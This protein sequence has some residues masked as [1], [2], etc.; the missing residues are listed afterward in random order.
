MSKYNI[1]LGEDLTSKFDAS[2][3]EKNKTV[4]GLTYFLFF[5]PFL[6]APDSKYARFHANQSLVLLIAYVLGLLVI[7]VVSTI[8]SILTYFLFFLFFLSIIPGIALLLLSGSMVYLFI[9]GLINGF[10]GKAKELPV[11]GY[12]K[13]IK[14]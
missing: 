7:G 13:V 11:I 12:L 2:D 8:I 14:L 3:I 6:A 1:N 5:L 10:T 4:A 9:L